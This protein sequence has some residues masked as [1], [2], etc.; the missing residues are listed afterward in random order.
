MKIF[1]FD[2]NVEAVT[3]FF[4]ILIFFFLILYL[5]RKVMA[6]KQVTCARSYVLA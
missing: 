3:F 4:L 1:V 5:P 6:T 2:Y